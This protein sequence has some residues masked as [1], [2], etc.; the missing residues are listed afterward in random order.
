MYLTIFVEAERVN[1]SKFSTDY[2][3]N[4][5]QLARDVQASII[6]YSKKGYK[7]DQIQGVNSAQSTVSYTQGMLLVFKNEQG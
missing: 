4:G 7:L 5:D 2:A 3:I 1:P 6:E